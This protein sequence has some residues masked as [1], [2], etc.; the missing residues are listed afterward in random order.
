MI[1]GRHLIHPGEITMILMSISGHYIAL[2][3]AGHGAKVLHFSKSR[4]PDQ[5][6]C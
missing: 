2:S 4:I 5:R 6:K 1:M 3:L